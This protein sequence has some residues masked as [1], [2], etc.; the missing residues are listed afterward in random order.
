MA[1]ATLPRPA[2]TGQTT[3]RPL[4]AGPAVALVDWSH[5]VE[6]YL[7]NIGLSFA[8]FRDEMTGGWMFGMIDALRTVGCPVVLFC[9][10]ARVAR[11]SRFTHR[12]TGAPLCVLP[13]PG[14]YQMVR[15]PIPNPYAA[16]LEEAAGPMHGAARPLLAV[17]KELAPYLATPVV[18]LARELRRYRC[19]AI[20]CQEYEN[21]RF[22]VCT[23]LGRLLRLPVFGIFQGG[24]APVARLERLLRPAVLRSCA[25]LVIAARK[26]AERVRVRYGV[27]A[28]C[29][30]RVFNPIDL[31]Q[32]RAADRDEARA[33]L[34]IPPDARVAVWHGRVLLPFKGL[35]VLLEAWEQI[36]RHRGGLDLRLLL[37]GTGSSAGELRARIAALRLRGVHWINE[38]LNDRRRIY[39]HLSAG[40]VYVLPSRHEGAPVAPV[41]AMACGLP[42]VASDVGG[43]PDILEHGEASGGVIVPPGDSAALAWALGRLLDDPVRA[44]ALGELARARAHS[45]FSLPSVGEQL[46][47]FL[48]SRGFRRARQS[49]PEGVAN[50]PGGPAA[51]SG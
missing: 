12:A 19:G 24:T 43:I 25:G 36:G 39:H 31:S 40:D 7:D 15:R 23:A 49:P 8:Q 27:P 22:D 28:S 9:F 18:A 29:I 38:Y 34:G 50:G 44:R 42:V 46:Y 37:V 20:L 51:P 32:C 45:C 11:V 14:V 1:R 10:S 3:V 16:S 35:D 41:E 21:P 26:E 4:G 47:G 30:A 33:E 2:S 6:D 17:L 13:A 48:C 5:L